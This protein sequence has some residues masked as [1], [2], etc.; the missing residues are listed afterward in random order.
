MASG[1]LVGSATLLEGKPGGEEED[2]G[3]ENAAMDWEAAGEDP[4]LEGKPG[5]EEEDVG[6]ENAAVDWEDAAVDWEAAGEDPAES[7]YQGTVS[8]TDEVASAT[9]AFEL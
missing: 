9:K 8:L 7:T 4:V 6:W 2:V 3:W 1:T 5:G